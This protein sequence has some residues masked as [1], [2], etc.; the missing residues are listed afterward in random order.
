MASGE[1]EVRQKNEGGYAFSW[2]EDTP[3]EFD[4]LCLYIVREFT[5]PDGTIGV[6]ALDVDLPRHLDSSLIDVDVHPTYISIVVKSK[7]L[8]L[9]LP[10]EVKA[11]ESKCQRSKVTGHLVVS[12][13]L[14]KSQKRAMETIFVKPKPIVKSS[15][16]QGR[17]QKPGK[18][19]GLVE[20]KTKTKSVQEMIM[21]EAMREASQE[22][23]PSIGATVEDSE[24]KYPEIES[25]D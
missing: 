5:R 15:T 25:I 9:K 1:A 4:F 23:S 18:P 12:M 16:G 8:R 11:G 19:I 10:E 13:P 20:R 3:G 24:S 6:I 14:V 7:L 17:S 21:E 22:S 2:N